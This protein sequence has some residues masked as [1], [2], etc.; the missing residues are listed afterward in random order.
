M[1]KAE[2]EWQ[3]L[4]DTFLGLDPD[5]GKQKGDQI[6]AHFGGVEKLATG[7]GS[8]VTNGLDESDEELELRGKHFGVNQ[9]ATPPL[10][11]YC[12]LVMETFKDPVLLILCAAVVVSLVV[13]TIDDPGHGWAEGVA[14]FISVVV[15]SQVCA[16]SDYR[17]QKQF[18]DLFKKGEAQEV[19]VVRRGQLIQIDKA[20]L[21]VGDIVKLKTGDKVPADGI[22]C[23]ETA[24]DLQLNEADL[25]G[26]S[27]PLEKTD[28]G[29]L[30]LH[31]DT[32]VVTGVGTMLLVAVGKDTLTGK[33]KEEL[34]EKEDEETPL[35]MKLGIMAELIGYVGMGAAVLTLLACVIRGAAVDWKWS[36]LLDSFIVAVTIVVVAVP[37]GLPLAVTIALAYSMGAMYKDNIFVKALSA[38]ETMGGATCICSDKTGTL[39]QGIMSV[40]GVWVGGESFESETK[41]ASCVPTIAEGKLRQLLIEGI[42]LNSDATITTEQLTEEELAARIQGDT[43][44]TRIKRVGNFTECALLTLIDELGTPGKYSETRKIVEE[45]KLKIK[46]WPFDSAKKRMSILVKGSGKD[47]M[48]GEDGQDNFYLKGAGEQVLALCSSYMTSDGSAKTID[49]A[50]RKSLEDYLSSKTGEGFRLM[51]MAH[52][53]QATGSWDASGQPP[54][55]DLT[56]L[57]VTAI[58]DP[59]REEVPEA[60]RM[61]KGA[62]VK[63][64][65]VT[66][67][68]K[69]TAKYI[70]GQCGIYIEA[71]G[72]IVMEAVDFR[73]LYDE[74]FLAQYG[75]RLQRYAKRD[76]KTDEEGVGTVAL[77]PY[78][79]EDGS[80]IP[81]NKAIGPICDQPPKLIEPGQKEKADAYNGFEK[82]LIRGNPEQLDMWAYGVK[83]VYDPSQWPQGI[84][85]SVE[86]LRLEAVQALLEEDQDQALKLKEEVAQAAGALAQDAAAKAD[87]LIVE[88]IDKLGL[89]LVPPADFRNDA[90]KQMT[91]KA[92]E[93][94]DGGPVSQALWRKVDEKLYKYENGVPQRL[95]GLQV[96]AR[97]L[98]NDKLKLVRRFMKCEEIVGVT[99]DGTNDA[100]ALRNANV[101]LAMGSG[102]QVARDAAHI[103]ILDDNFVSIIQAIKWGRNIFDNI[104]K[105]LQFQLTVNITALCLTF[106]MACIVD[107]DISE[108]LPLNAVMLLWVNLIMD[109]MGALAL[110]TE[111]PT[112][113]LLDRPPHGKERLLSVSMMRMLLC[114]SVYQLAVLMVLSSDAQF[115]QDFCKG[116]NM[117]GSKE[118]DPNGTPGWSGG[119]CTKRQ[120]TFVFNTFVFCQFWNEINCRKLKE[121]NIFAGFFDSLMFTFV[122]VFTFLLQVFMV[123][124]GGEDFVGTNGLDGWQWLV[125]IVIGMGAIPVG[126]IARTIP[127]AS[128]EAKFDYGRDVGHVEDEDEEEEEVVE[129]DSEAKNLLAESGAETKDK[130]I[131]G[132]G[133][134]P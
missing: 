46:S 11:T 128:L 9:F 34:M 35:Q 5:Q 66:G 79:N 102:T 98:P 93:K 88:A 18:E 7:L 72:G 62:G 116:N 127:I 30:Y 36:I 110:A 129:T 13:G 89:L 107:G 73:R 45:N 58:L 119:I 123:E 105:F 112:D 8:S 1:P 90:W 118:C 15:V 87:P 91:E 106:I 65:M 19:A 29:D 16:I 94:A 61:A 3:T 69:D 21:L 51:V 70:A 82:K 67:D 121:F 108:Q 12:E 48:C 10:A 109:S 50:M 95:G 25:T 60:V 84:A 130:P 22:L 59:L 114:Q 122:L 134:G 71:N 26:E 17:K 23:P 38:C 44:T 117:W 80:E 74:A 43:A 68:H 56:L 97:S 120:N 54:E 133:V 124:A 37:E 20:E 77:C 4:Q 64:L 100:P 49:E 40:T 131:D 99:G 63:V 78:E 104:R 101:G 92:Q 14:I 2:V 33:I 31:A 115:I 57:A 55:K 132:P 42:A 24:D 113:A 32:F 96:L 76:E 86:K 6:K 75:T 126:L 53:T 28:E 83:N 39:T 41:G 47:G 27:M 52:K 81:W 111:K 85:E 125:S 103:T